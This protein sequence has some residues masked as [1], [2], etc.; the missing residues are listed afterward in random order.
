MG[1]RF[2]LEG[3]IGALMVGQLRPLPDRAGV[4]GNELHGGLLKPH[5]KLFFRAVLELE[6]IFNG[7]NFLIHLPEI[8]ITTRSM[9]PMKKSSRHEHKGRQG[10]GNLKGQNL[11]QALLGI[12]PKVTPRNKPIE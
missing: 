4:F 5:G 11:C 1:V 7:D 3:A 2:R 12:R 10:R 9:K 6:L 8:T